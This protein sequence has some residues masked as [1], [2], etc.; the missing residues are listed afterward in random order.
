MKLTSKKY[1]DYALVREMLETV[2]VVKGFRHADARSF[3][4]AVKRTAKDKVFFTGEGSSRIFPAKNAIA[5]CLQLGLSLNLQTDGARQAAEYDLN[6]FAVFGASNSGRTVELVDLFRELGRAK[7]KALFGLTAFDETLLGKASHETQVLSCG[8]ED[9]VA[10]TKSVVEQALFYHALVSELG[11]KRSAEFKGAAKLPGAIRKSLEMT[12]PAS[13]VRK[14]ARA[15]RVYFAGRND[16]VAEELTLKTNE[17]TRK[18]SAFLEG[19][20][21]VHGV[22]E[23]MDKD[24]IVIVVDP[25]AKEVA[26]FRECLEKGV[27]LTLVAISSR[28]QDVPTIRIPACGAFTPYVQ[29]AVGWNLLVEIGLANKI[30]LDHPVRARKVGNEAPGR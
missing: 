5:R 19:T 17:I 2:E 27:G 13:V 24:D 10:A 29:L 16:G 11:K 4:H 22:E 12:I 21:A 28:K 3:A 20:Y 7:H 8:K 14:A 18:P 26:K 23:V 6:G 9:A 30:D 25:Y 15:K 1:K